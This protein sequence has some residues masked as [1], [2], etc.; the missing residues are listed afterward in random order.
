MNKKYTPGPWKVINGWNPD[1]SPRGEASRFPSILMMENPNEG[2]PY[3]TKLTVNASHNQEAESIMANAYLIAAAPE[4][5]EV[6][7]RHYNDALD[8]GDTL[9]ADDIEY[10]DYREIRLTIAKAKGESDD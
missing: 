5:L 1:G 7:E 4:L 9:D 8:R 6:L 2:R 3:T 10:D